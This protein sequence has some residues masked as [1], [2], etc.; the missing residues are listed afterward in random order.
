MLFQHLFNNSQISARAT[1]NDIKEFLEKKDTILDVGS[2]TGLVAQLIKDGLNAEIKCV[3]VID[4]NKSRIPT[5]LFDGEHLP[6]KDNSFSVV[7]CCWVLHHTNYNTQEKLL[8]EM[9]RV[10]KSKVIVCEDTATT[11]YDKIFQSLHSIEA[12][13]DYQSTKLDFRSSEEWLDLFKKLNLKLMDLSAIPRTGH[14]IWYPIP[15]TVFVLSTQ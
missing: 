10:S 2:G 4:V 12:K 1:F 7:I 13:V 8:K 5:T 9:M 6:F 15:R 3:D 14:Q 11:W